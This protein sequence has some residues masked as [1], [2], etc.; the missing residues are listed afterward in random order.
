MPFLWLT[1]AKLPTA[2]RV[3]VFLLGLVLLWL[4]IAL[5][6]YW[7]S[8]TGGLA[9]GG[10]IATGLLYLLFLLLWPVWGRRVYGLTEPW[11]SLGLVRQPSL[12][13]DALIGFLLG[14]V[15][16]TLLVGIQWGLGWTRFQGLA[17]PPLQLVTE[18]LLVGL[19]VGFAE[20]IL[21]RGWL[22]L[23][24]E[25]D[26]RPALALWINGL[27]FAAV[28]FIKPLPA[29]L[30]TLPQF[31]GLLLLGVTLVWARRA[32]SMG[33]SQTAPSL[34]WPIGLHGGLVGAYYVVSV[35]QPFTPT[36]SVPEWVTG[37]HQNPL[38]GLMGIGLLGAIAALFYQKAHLHR[39]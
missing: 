2:A 30:A 13:V 35:G 16:V 19:A 39:S 26:Y 12:L 5:P 27:I 33:L 8:D 15:G 32:P 20:E 22:L 34:G 38:A 31:F 21:F 10:S 1:V 24:L 14:V 37:I 3:G 23:E 11:R 28:H 25:R 29:I 6:L 17:T 9:L 7:L 18:A 36:G 4:P